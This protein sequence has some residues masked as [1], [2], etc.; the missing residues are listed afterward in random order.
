MTTRAR[1]QD[2]PATSTYAP[3]LESGMD[4]PAAQALIGELWESSCLPALANF[5]EVPSQSPL[6]DPEWETNG[7]L[8]QSIQ[9]LVSWVRAQDIPGLT[10]DLVEK[11]GFTPVIFIEVAPT[12]KGADA[13]TVLMYGH[14]DTQP[15]FVGWSEGLQP[16]KATRKDGKLYGRGACDDGYSIFCAV[17]AIKALKAQPQLEHG[18]LLFLME[19]SEESGSVHLPQHLGTLKERI[20]TPNLIVCLDSGCGNYE[21]L[22]VTTS[23]RGMVVGEL[24]VSVSTALAPLNAQPAPPAPTPCWPSGS[25]RPAQLTETHRAQLTTTPCRAGPEGRRPLRRRLGHRALLLPRAAP[26]TRP[27]RGLPP[28]SVHHTPPVGSTRARSPSRDQ[29]TQH[30][31]CWLAHLLACTPRAALPCKCVAMVRGVVGCQDSATGVVKPTALWADIPAQRKEQAALAATV[32]GKNIVGQF[33]FHE[34]ALPVA[35][36]ARCFHLG[37]GAY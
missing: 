15:P 25:G 1:P 18:R 9:I 7:L 22:W 8:D 34:G 4:L 16:Y 10:V 2:E 3:P 27:G 37:I 29:P 23:L 36:R 35:V 12:P 20:G 19:A 17:A 28:P 33:P 5:V 13:G 24:S 11:K 30:A 6:F 21:Q 14:A 31:G 32:L 26:A